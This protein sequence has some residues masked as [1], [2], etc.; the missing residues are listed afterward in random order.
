MG[1]WPQTGV[2]LAGVGCAALVDH[3]CAAS[4]PPKFWSHLPE[5]YDGTSNPSEFLQ[6][7]VTAITVAGGNIA[8]M[9]TY[10]HVALSGPAWTW[11][12]NL[13]PGSVYSWE[14]LCARFVPN[15]ASA[16]Q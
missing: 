13:T 7:Y 6:V 4:W 12:M 10:F 8:V 5:K 11:L 2:P 3:L 14:E 9:A 1:T 16:Y 15:F